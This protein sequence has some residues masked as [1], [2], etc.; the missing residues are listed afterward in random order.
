MGLDQSALLD[1]LGELKLKAMPTIVSL[2]LPGS[3]RIR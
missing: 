3:A 1:L 2:F